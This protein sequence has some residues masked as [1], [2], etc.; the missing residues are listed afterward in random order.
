MVTRRL[1]A[2]GLLIVFGLSSAFA[3]SLHETARK[4][5][6]E[7]TKQHLDQGAA[8]EERDATGETPL[9]LAALAGHI[10]IVRLLISRGV[11]VQA[12]NKK[13]LTPLHAAAY[14]G[15][16]DI[17]VLL[18][19]KGAQVDDSR[20]FF[21]ITPL[22]AAAEENH[23]DMV[24]LLVAKGANL[25]AKEKNGITPLTKAGW[26]EHWEVFSVLKKAGPTCQPLELVGDWLYNECSKRE[27]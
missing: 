7:R 12:R 15:R 24:E 8:L 19:E 27:D 9:I 2:T 17:A 5:Q 14:G 1:L 25:E 10:E 26:R 16:V 13:G 6:V 21:S 18:I 20:N 23:K 4:G 3:G 22:H 11:D